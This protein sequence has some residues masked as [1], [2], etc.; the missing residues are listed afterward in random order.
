M[1]STEQKR[2]FIID[3]YATLYRAHYALIRNPL[4]NT[5]GT[6]TSAIFGFANQVFQLIDEEKPDYLVAAFDSKGKNFRHEIFEEYK[7]NRSEMPDEIQTQLPYLWKLLEGMNIPVLRVDGVE[8]DDI[9]GTVAKQCG[10]IDLQCNIVSGD[11]DFMQLINDSTFLYAP[12]ARKREKEI[13]DVNKV[14]E[15]WGVGPENII[16]LLGLMGDSSDNVPGV[17]GV[18]PKTAMKLIQKHGSIEKI[19]ENID[20]I[21]NEKMKDKLLSDK[22]NALLSKQL[23]TILTDVNIDSSVD[24]FVIKEMNTSKL[25]DIFKE[26]EFSGMLK[27]IGSTETIEQKSVDRKKDYKNILNLEDLIG[28]VESLEQGKWLSVDL[29]TTS[30][31]PMAAEIVGFSFSTKKDTG[32]YVPILFKDKKENL[33]GNNDLDEVIRILKPFLEDENIPKTGQ[34]IK[35]DALIMKRFGIDLKGIEFDTMIA[36]HLL[37]PNARSYKLDNLSLAHLN[38][39]MVPIKD[40]IGVGKNQITMDQVSL[41]DISFYAAEDADVVIELTEIFMKDLKKQKLFN[42]FKSIEIDLL[43]VLIDMQFNGIFIDKEYLEN[44][45]NEIGKKIESLESEIINL[46]GEEFN[47]NSSQQLAVILFDKLKLPMIKKRSTAEAVLS[48]LKDKHPLPELILSYRKLY[49]LK[50]TYLDP[51]PS[52]IIADTQRVHSSFNQTMTATGRLSTSSPNFQNIPI[53]TEDGKEIRKAIKAQ[54]NEY[55]IFSADYSQVELRVMAHLSGDESLISALNN[56]E[57]IHTSTAKHIFNVDNDDMVLPE[58]R[59]IAKIVNFGIMYGAGPFRLSQELDI[60]FGE[61]KQI[62]DAY[63]Q[64]YQGIEQYIENS[65][66]QIKETKSVETL[67]GR[68]R[69]VWDS[70][71]QNKIRRDAAE[72]MAINMPIQGTAAEMIKLA[73]I[74]I[75][76]QMNK[77]N[78]KSKLI[79]QIHDELLLEVHQ[80]EIDYISKMVIEHMRNAMKL[81]V[82]IEIDFG[83]GPSWYEAH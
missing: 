47:L 19:Y 11:K 65:K 57:D 63:F 27:K 25:E 72:R 1:S 66:L 69:A 14:V 41:D 28:F 67:L 3:G 51:L 78:L 15:K 50:N 30:V 77:E 39:K 12:Q 20:S 80:D 21:K 4:T 79:M 55:Q 48:E 31:N 45:S 7:A 42:Y 49:K 52:Y 71:S 32:F 6:P 10:D 64:K 16:D 40:L 13:F 8:A 24:D 43:P 73:M 33:F 58:M 23:V 46:A 22:D 36:A 76:R 61:A 44:R 35:Y 82:P 70:D 75:H 18:G 74:K 26:L 54:S 81:D 29:E 38:Y 34:N 17:Q 37:N 2:L 68:R 62:K 60:P 9:I 83:I 59:R 5:A 53:R 56:G